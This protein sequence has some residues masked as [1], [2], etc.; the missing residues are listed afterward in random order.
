MGV[1]ENDMKENRNDGMGLTEKP[2]QF[3]LKLSQLCAA[4]EHNY[5]TIAHTAKGGNNGIYL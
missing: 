3:I 5:H 1:P 4:K 2:L